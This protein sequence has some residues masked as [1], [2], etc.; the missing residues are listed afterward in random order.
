MSKNDQNKS[1]Q[2]IAD[3]E[4]DL[5]TLFNDDAIPATV[6][7]LAVRNLVLF[8]GVV[9]P[10]LIGRKESMTLMN[11]AENSGMVIG[12]VCQRD[13]EVE[14]PTKEDLY[15]Y[16]VYAKVIRQLSMPNG[17]TT[18][19]IQAMGR[20]RLTHIVKEKPYLMGLTESDREMEPEKADKEFMTASDDLKQLIEEYVESNDEIPDEA[21]FA[22]RNISNPILSLNFVCSNMPFSIK[23]KMRLL[24]MNNIK[25]RLFNVMKIINREISLQHLKKDI[26]EK[27]RD[28]IDEQQR[29]YFLQQQI[30]N[31]QAEI[32]N[33]ETSPEK[34][35]LLQKAKSKK[36]TA[37][38]E[39]IFNK[40]MGK[41]DNLNPQSPDYN[42]Q[43][44]YLQTLVSLPWN[45][46]TTDDLNLDRA[47]KI[48]DPQGSH[49]LSLRS[50]GR[51]KDIAGKEY[52]R[53]HETQICA[54]LTGRSARRGRNPRTPQNLYRRDA[55]TNHQKHPESGIEQSGIHPRRDRQDHTG[56]A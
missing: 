22:V 56:Y 51:G 44:T 52:R 28:D 42:V 45:E 11:R 53:S 50:S 26:R 36:W 15:K 24:E 54:Y 33:G 27:T 16:G 48:L 31:L 4:G 34:K 35:E 8:P 6:P 10:I 17:G 12:V 9:A 40:E 32:G 41:L 47:Q 18:A 1:F 38:V 23:E 29:N 37:E 49:H 2:M 13:P 30:K 25:E 46:Y 21:T 7:I 43:L 55:R 19:I 5:D 20:M 39:K 14:K 3:I